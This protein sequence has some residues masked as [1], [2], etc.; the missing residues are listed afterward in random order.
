VS[1]YLAGRV[2]CFP[3]AKGKPIELHPPSSVIQ[4]DQ[5]KERDS[6]VESAALASDPEF[7]PLLTGWAGELVKLLMPTV[8]AA[9]LTIFTG[10]LTTLLINLQDVNIKTQEDKASRRAI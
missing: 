9:L 4:Q 8:R 3:L 1:D 5:S 6:L 2:F 10:S 7:K